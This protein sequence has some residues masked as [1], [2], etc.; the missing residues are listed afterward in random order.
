MSE[1]P[2]RYGKDVSIAR[3]LA[4][5]Q[6]GSILSII[7]ALN[8]G[9]LRPTIPRHG[10]STTPTSYEEFAKMYAMIYNG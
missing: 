6:P 5:V 4:Q 8:E 3:L 9:I 1:T 10:E 2:P 7:S